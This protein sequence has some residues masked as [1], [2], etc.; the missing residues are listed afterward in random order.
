MKT[1]SLLKI[2]A[3]FAVIL[4]A[5]CSKDNNDTASTLTATDITESNK[6]VSAGDDVMGLVESQLNVTDG[7]SARN[8][9]FLPNCATVTR[10]PVTGFPAVGENI[11]KTIDFGSGCLMPNGNTL[12]GKIVLTFPYLPNATSHI[13]TC[14]FDNFYHNDIKIEGTKT[15]TRTVTANGPT[16]I[17][18]MDITATHP[19]GHIH[20]KVGRITR[21]MTAGYLTPSL[22]DNEYS[23]TGNWTNTS[24]GNV[25][26]ATITSPIIV[27][28][29]CNH[30]VQGVISFVKGI[31]T[32]TLDYGNGDCDD[33]AIFTLN[34]VA[35]TIT[36]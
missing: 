13:I 26:T 34:G 1:N 18:D 9:Q 11:T 8:V 12:K 17:V 16:V 23:I 22:L 33:L 7:I 6:L 5:S 4:F 36:L 27:K 35:H 20:H 3:L 10:N 14:T 28:L 29:N 2:V 31:N 30:I 19:N 15:F 32:A 25:M 24:N 21:V